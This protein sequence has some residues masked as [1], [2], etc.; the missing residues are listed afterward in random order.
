MFGYI[1]PNMGELKMKDVELYRSVYCG[2]CRC[3]GKNISH[4]TRWLLNYDFVYLAIVR[5]A[6]TGEAYSLAPHRCGLTLRKR[7]MM[8]EN[9]SLRFTV[10][11]FGCLIYYKALDDV[12]DTRGL[13]R[14][15]RRLLLPVSRRMLVKAEKLYP[16]IGETISAPIARLAQLEKEGCSIPD[17]AADCFAGMMRA[18]ASFGL[19]GSGAAVAGEIGYHVG[20]F[21]Y[22]IDE[23]DDAA[24]DSASGN[25]NVLLSAFGGIDGVRKNSKAIERTLLDSGAYISRSYALADGNRFDEIIYN[26]AE[27][28][29]AAAIRKV[30]TEEKVK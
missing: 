8:D 21:V 5:M 20:R 4:F 16:G 2:L 23:L 18:V 7:P 3:G 9:E 24:D 17:Q 27:L 1:R 6:I 26:I 22:L 19:T 29:T 14:L 25:Y 12:N 15:F 11:A 28:G 10:A 13:K 30:T